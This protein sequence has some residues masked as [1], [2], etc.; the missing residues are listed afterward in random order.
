MCIDWVA[1]NFRYADFQE[2][3]N[4][5]KSHWPIPYSIP[6]FCPTRFPLEPDDI[7]ECHRS[8]FDQLSIWMHQNHLPSTFCTID[9]DIRQ[10]IRASLYIST[11]NQ[12]I[13]GKKNLNFHLNRVDD[14][15]FNYQFVWCSTDS[16]P[17]KVH[18]FV[19]VYR[20]GFALKSQPLQS[21]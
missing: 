3:K 10:S 8:N 18:R 17:L 6:I 13:F 9:G 11:K 14:M 5:L 15:N 7:D 19:V 4:R 1:C 16:Q 12:M 20:V 2:F 21:V